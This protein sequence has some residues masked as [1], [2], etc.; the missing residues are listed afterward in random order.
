MEQ[1]PE[2]PR[3]AAAMAPLSELR[4]AP[5]HEHAAV[6]ADVQERLDQIL[7]ATSAPAEGATA[8]ADAP[9]AGS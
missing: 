5:V 2:D 6:Y 4:E 1:T 8:D 9:P 3:V 7:A